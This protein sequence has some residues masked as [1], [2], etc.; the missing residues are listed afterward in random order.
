MQNE[1]I[2]ITERFIKKLQ[3]RTSAD[4]LLAFYHQDIE[5]IEFPNPLNKN[6]TIR[7]LEDLKRAAENGK[8]VLQKETY[9]IIRS[10]AVDN[11][12]IIEAT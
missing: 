10:F 9:N 7:N 1:L 2:A 3:D 6:T 11:K 4:E 12:V 8:K 5:Q